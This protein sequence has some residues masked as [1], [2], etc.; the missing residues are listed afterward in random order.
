MSRPYISHKVN[1]CTT[2]HNICDGH[3]HVHSTR[4]PRAIA[5][6]EIRN[7][8]TYAKIVCDRWTQR[9][10]SLQQQIASS[11]L[12][13][14]HTPCKHITSH[15]ITYLVCIS[16]MW[17]CVDTQHT[18]I[19]VEQV[20]LLSLI[21]LHIR[22]HEKKTE[23][24]DV[25]LEYNAQIGRCETNAIQLNADTCIWLSHK[26][27]KCIWTCKWGEEIDL[28]PS[29]MLTT[30]LWNIFALCIWIFES[31]LRQRTLYWDR[32]IRALNQT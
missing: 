32:C 15:R 27:I 11:F 9:E 14:T 20:I 25:T 19:C 16:A 18:C 2:Q 26:E 7:F 21:L 1:I 10:T 13:H 6:S 12:L 29:S 24:T 3:M 8:Q 31:V 28:M 23:V 30:S 4:K 17:G 22:I 5:P